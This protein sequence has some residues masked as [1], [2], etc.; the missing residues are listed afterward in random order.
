MD[1]DILIVPLHIISD[2]IAILRTAGHARKECV[3]LWLTKSAGDQRWVTEVFVPDQEAEEDFFW[4]APASMSRILAHLRKSDLYVG[5]QVHS[6]PKEAFHSAADDRWALVRHVSA[7]SIVVPY[8]A[9]DTTPENFVGQTA[10]FSLS[11]HN[12]WVPI[13]PVHVHRHYRI[14]L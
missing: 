1:S 9:Q 6:H 2:S 7:L 12:R 10:L 3:V 5:A 13:L 14:E 8:F 4:I 11:V